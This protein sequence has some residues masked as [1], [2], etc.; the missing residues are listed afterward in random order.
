MLIKTLDRKS[1]FLQFKQISGVAIVKISNY[2]Q[3]LNYIPRESLYYSRDH[4]PD[5]LHIHIYIPIV[6]LETDVAS[7]AHTRASERENKLGR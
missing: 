2:H 6:N 5:A 4:V 1:I 3:S 7:E